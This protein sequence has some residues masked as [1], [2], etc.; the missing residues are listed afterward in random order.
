[1]TPI[2]NT[3]NT[4]DN[5]VEPKLDIVK[6]VM[7]RFKEDFPNTVPMPFIIEYV[8]KYLF[9]IISRELILMNNIHIDGF[10]KF[11]ITAKHSDKIN[12]VQYYP[13][14]R[15]SRAFIA[16]MRDQLDTA[17]ISDKRYLESREQYYK[18]LDKVRDD[19]TISTRGFLPESYLKSKERFQAKLQN[20]LRNLQVHKK[21]KEDIQ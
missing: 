15:F 9:E 7:A 3:D 19:Y 21:A 6:S 17:T 5:T 4:A 18:T 8:I 20:R 10:G 16:L 13:K 14:F 12:K 2:E 11:M 1:M